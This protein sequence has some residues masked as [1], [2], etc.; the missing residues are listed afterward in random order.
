MSFNKTNIKVSIIVNCHNG[1]KYLSDAL[2]S[3][4]NQTY[5]NY[6][7][8]FW[9]NA[10][11]DDSKIIYQNFQKTYNEKK[12]IYFENSIKLSL[13]HARNEALK[14]VRGDF[15]CFLDADDMWL[16]DKLLHNLNKFKEGNYDIIFSNIFITYKKK[17]NIYIKKKIDEKKI[18]ENLIK[19]YN[20]SLVSIMIK[21]TIIEKQIHN[22]NPE[23]DHIGD[24]D[25]ILRMAKKHKFGYISEPLAVY[26][27]HEDNLTRTNRINEINEMDVWIK[28]NTLGL[29]HKEIKP[30]K[31]KILE[32]KLIY[33]RLN[34]DILKAL[35]IF[36]KISFKLKIKLSIVFFIPKKILDRALSF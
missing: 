10:S 20:A 17:K 18:Y 28:N 23:Y 4:I 2:N 16:Q 34:G 19:K 32:R 27:L 12:L 24:F 9:N 22:F 11:T 29:S 21:K 26:R 6:E 33:Y 13:Y 14:L 30:I 36:F 8:I 5:K 3:I 15:I 25:F 35:L 7:V 31:N 1:A